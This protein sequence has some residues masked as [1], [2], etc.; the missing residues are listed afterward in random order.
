MKSVRGRFRQDRHK[1]G[2][3]APKKSDKSVTI[4]RKKISI[5]I[6]FG[7]LPD[8]DIFV[9]FCEKNVA[10]DTGEGEV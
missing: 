2:R 6:I 9:V 7:K 3:Q 10:K 5:I 4:C 1:G 8:S